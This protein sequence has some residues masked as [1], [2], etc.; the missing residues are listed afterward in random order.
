VD[1]ITDGTIVFNLW[2]TPLTSTANVVAA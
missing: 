1:A 2:W